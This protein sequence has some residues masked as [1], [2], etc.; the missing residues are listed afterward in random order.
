MPDPNTNLNAVPAPSPLNPTNQPEPQQLTLAEPGQILAPE[1]ANLRIYIGAAPGVGKT[2]QMLETA[3]L[4]RH[5]GIDVVIGLIETHGRADT[6]GDDQRPRDHAAQRHSLPLRRP[7][8]DGPR[9]RSPASS[10]HRH[11]RRAGA[12]QRSRLAQPQ[13]L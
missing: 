1:P 4:M 12:H 11:R 13:A 10:P 7:P 6:P 8:R 5:Q 3:H 9:R 2:F